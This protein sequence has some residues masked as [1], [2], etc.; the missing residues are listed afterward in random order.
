MPRG[1]CE[2]ALGQKLAPVFPHMNY[3][4]MAAF[5]KLFRVISALF[6]AILAYQKMRGAVDGKPAI[7]ARE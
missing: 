6:D 3:E 1:L 4:V 2:I 5:P 7:G